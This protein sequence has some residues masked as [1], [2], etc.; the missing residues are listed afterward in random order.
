MYMKVKEYTCM[1]MDKFTRAASPMVRW[2]D[3]EPTTTQ[4]GRLTIEA[5]GI[6]EL[7]M[8]EALT[9]AKNKYTKDSGLKELNMDRVAAK[10][11]LQDRSIKEAIVK[12]RDK[13][14]GD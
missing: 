3:K 7:S 2:K 6:K 9:P 5:N 14:R 13:G 11:E 10:I 8:E 1:E 12:E 4:R